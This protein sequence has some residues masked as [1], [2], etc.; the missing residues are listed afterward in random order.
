MLGIREEKFI[1]ATGGGRNGKGLITENFTYLLGPYA[2]TMHLSLL[3]QPIKAGANTE[4]RNLHKKRFIVASEPDEGSFE[5]LRSSNIKK[6]TGDENHNAR[7]LYS[8]DDKTK[9]FSTIVMECNK[10]PYIKGEKGV[11]ILDRITVV[12]GH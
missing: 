8:D 6:L 9:I 5:Q 1:T 10:L 4:L 2:Q 7:G 12:S 11:A 3:T